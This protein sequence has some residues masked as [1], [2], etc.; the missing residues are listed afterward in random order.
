MS[1]RIG[2]ELRFARIVALIHAGIFAMAVPAI[3]GW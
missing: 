3:V 2:I 1:S